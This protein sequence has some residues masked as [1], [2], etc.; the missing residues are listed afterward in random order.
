MQFGQLFKEKRES[1]G[2]TLGHIEEET[3]I[4]KLYLDAIE[5]ERFN[6][7]PPRVYATGFVKKYARYLGLDEQVMVQQFVEMA[8]GHDE[9]EVLQPQPQTKPV[10][11]DFQ[12]Y[13]MNWRNVVVAGV[14]LLAAL[15]V[16]NI[17]VDAISQNSPDV[18]NN[19]PQQQNTP[20]QQPENYTPG[21][22]VAP[23]SATQLAT[24][25]VAALSDCWVKAIVDGQT[26][27]SSTLTAGQEKVFEGREAVLLTVGNAGGI[28]IYYNGNKMGPLGESGEVIHKEFRV[29]HL[30]S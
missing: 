17:I 26:V 14:F 8:Y 7:L 13:G 16:G 2:L 6:I 30:S 1:L 28:E 23:E 24:V 27:F 4:R 18:V 21:D 20:A 5:K 11:P 3:K 29:A 12:F 15:W 9:V 19:P 25:R 22:N 10:R